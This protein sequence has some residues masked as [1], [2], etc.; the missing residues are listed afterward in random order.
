LRWDIFI[1]IIAIN[2]FVFV[3]FLVESDSAVPKGVG[4]GVG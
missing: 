1:I 3:F 4:A 2:F